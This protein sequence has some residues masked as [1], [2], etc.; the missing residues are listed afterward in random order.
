MLMLVGNCIMEIE[1]RECQTPEK[2]K[3]PTHIIKEWIPF[4]EE[5]LKPREG[6][7]F[8][9]LKE[10][11][12]FYK[13]Y[14]HHVGFSVRKSKYK[15]TKEGSHKYKERLCMNF[16]PILSRWTKMVGS[17][18]IF[19]VNGIIL[20]GHSQMEH[21]DKLILRNW[22]DFLD[23]TPVARRDLEMLILVSKGI[24]NI[25]KEVKHLNDSTSERN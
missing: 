7:E 9:N 6:L 8:A 12:K 2:Y 22:L 5:E 13:F 19:D 20:E 18:P 14:A 16:H 24:Q 17:K 23:C 10:C 3:S 15:K 25:L 1:K 4:C 21:E 11:E